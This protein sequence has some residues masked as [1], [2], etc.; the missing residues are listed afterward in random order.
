LSR[1]PQSTCTTSTRHRCSHTTNTGQGTPPSLASR[2][3]LLS[4]LRQAF[5]RCAVCSGPAKPLLLFSR[6]WATRCHQMPPHRKRSTIQYIVASQMHLRV[7]ERV[8][9]PAEHLPVTPPRPARQ[10]QRAAFVRVVTNRNGAMAHGSYAIHR[11]DQVKNRR[12]E[13]DARAKNVPSDME[14]GLYLSG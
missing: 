9:T 5:I 10:S 3:E 13:R 14:P 7:A 12:K 11:A 4:Y 8:T 2:V 1:L 6:T